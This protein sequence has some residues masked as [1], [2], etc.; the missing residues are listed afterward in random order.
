MTKE[1]RLHDQNSEKDATSETPRTPKKAGGLV[2]FLVIL[3]VAFV[4]VF[5]FV[6]PFVLE[7]FRIPSESMVPTLLVGDRVFVNKFIYRLTE[8]ERGDVVVFESVNGGEEDLI[9][10]IVALAGDEVEVRNGTLLVNGEAREEPYLNRNLPF[11][12]SYGP[13]EVPE[14]HVF[15]M[16]DNRANSAD[17]RVFGPLPIENIEGE[18]FVRFWPPLR[19]GSL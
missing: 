3:A 19:I 11:N 5:G 10:R 8:P 13:S 1:K 4:L 9:K 14:G 12:D 6:R 2:E 18:A 15:V 7:A 16:G 17:S